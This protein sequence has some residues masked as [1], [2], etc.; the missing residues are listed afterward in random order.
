MRRLLAALVLSLP[1]AGCIEADLT[2]DF[3][4]ATNVEVVS[5]VGMGAELMAMTGQSLEE[6]CN[7]KPGVMQGE[8]V[9]CE[10]T[11]TMT[12]AELEAE[13]AKGGSDDPAA[14]LQN[15]FKIEHPDSS[16][17]KVTLDFAT[18]TASDQGEEARQMAAMM[19]EMF[20]GSNITLRVK[21]P[22]IVET[23]GTLSADATT[24][25]VSIAL[26]DL[27]AQTPPKPFVTLI[28]TSSCFLWVFC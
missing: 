5:K 15:A 8:K 24:S 12:V 16:H 21:G 17:I 26:K 27:L 13:I 9:L 28:Q 11:R 23:T 18:L 19:G 22:K 20:E 2:L 10:D 6:V 3:K 4:D 14:Q 25:E 1:L 7:G